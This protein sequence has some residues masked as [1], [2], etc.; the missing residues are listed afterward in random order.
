ML[1]M[2]RWIPFVVI[3]LLVV[4]GIGIGL[5]YL[6]LP[7]PV[8]APNIA[9]GTNYKIKSMRNGLYF[10]PDAKGMPIANQPVTLVKND[11]SYC[12]FENNFKTF[13]IVFDKAGRD[14]ETEM[15]FV[16][17]K[18]KRGK[19]KLDATVRQIYDGKL[20][21]FKIRTTID[22][23]IISGTAEYKVAVTSLNETSE[24]VEE[25]YRDN[26]IVMTFLRSAA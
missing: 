9:I 25:I 4:V 17:T 24:P 16:V 18:I 10:Y 22:K 23:I 5:Y 19:G 13:K 15:I 21:E 2:K 3:V 11:T 7:K 6:V 20:R 14:K 26:S 12:V 8:D 1:L